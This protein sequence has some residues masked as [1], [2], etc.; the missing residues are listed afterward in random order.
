MP[1]L[2]R[3]SGRYYNSLCDCTVGISC[4][5]VHMLALDGLGGGGA[6]SE[7]SSHL[8][9]PT[10]TVTLDRCNQCN[11]VSIFFTL[12]VREIVLIYYNNMSESD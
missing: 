2:I 5:N 11:P 6:L 10:V 3:L 12:I 8:S 1:A 7:R 4:S 9:C